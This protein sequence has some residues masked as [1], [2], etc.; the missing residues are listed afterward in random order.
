VTLV[1]QADP[2]GNN[3]NPR[4]L[5]VIRALSGL[6]I[7]SVNVVP[8]TA[9]QGEVRISDIWFRGA[10]QLAVSVVNLPAGDTL[11]FT[12]NRLTNIM[13][14]LFGFRFGIAGSGALPNS[15]E[16]AGH[17]AIRDNY[18][19]TTGIPFLLGDDNGVA[20]QNVQFE[21]IEITGNTSITNGESMEVEQHTGRKVVLSDNFIMTRRVT[22]SLLGLKTELPAFPSLDGG[23][24]PASIKWAGNDTEETIITNNE[25]YVGS[26]RTAVCIG[27]NLIDPDES[28]YAKRTTVITNNTCTMSPGIIGDGIFA[29]MML[30]WSGENPFYDKG[31]L[32]N[33][34]VE[35]NTLVGRAQFG[36]T[37]MDF[38]VPLA[39]ANDLINT[40]HDNV[41]RGNDF[42]QF[43]PG[44]A[45]VYFGPSTF[46]N[47]FE[48]DPNGPVIDEGT[49]NSITP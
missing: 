15:V 27:V 8:G 5:T 26:S 31:S 25:I 24:H 45:S 21:T 13:Q 7:L 41:F 2:T 6:G 14:G 37:M 40:S 19:N 49:N 16:L 30:G 35:D 9:P 10:G 4:D 38:H 43:S 39:P 42:S 12:R 18:I 36:I 29:G 1:G 11:T 47:V 23:G 32:E 22:P 44:T 3:P 17:V 46:D 20:F 33:A 28:V 34:I 48:G